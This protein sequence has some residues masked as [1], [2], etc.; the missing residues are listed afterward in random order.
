MSVVWALVVCLTTFTTPLQIGHYLMCVINM[1]ASWFEFSYYH[2]THEHSICAQ[3]QHVHDIINY[4]VL[5]IY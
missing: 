1:I 4:H 5:Y 3:I 2:S